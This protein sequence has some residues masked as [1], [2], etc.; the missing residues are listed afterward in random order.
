[1]E[2]RRYLL[3]CRNIDC[4][5]RGADDLLAAVQQRFKERGINDIE[6]KEYMCFGACHEAPNIVLHPTREWYSRVTIED[7]DAIIDEICGGPP[8]NHLKNHIDAAHREFI[9]Q[10]LDAGLF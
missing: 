5:A 8:A 10:L 4:K 2:G 6:I 7:I 3:V 9:F 1:M